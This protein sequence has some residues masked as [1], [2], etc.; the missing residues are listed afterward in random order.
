MVNE[1]SI[2]CYNYMTLAA[3]H[4]LDMPQD[5][6]VHHGVSRIHSKDTFRPEEVKEGDVVFVKT[7]FLY[8]GQFCKDY[9]PKIKHPFI[10]V[11][12]VSSYQVG[13]NGN[14]DY[15]ELLESK[16]VIKWFC[17]NPPIFKSEKVVPIPIGL[18][19]YE[20]PG[21]NQLILKMFNDREFSKDKIEKAYLPYHTIGNN[22]ARAKSIEYLKT[23]D[24]VEVE[25]EKLGF[26]D[27]L[28]K[29]S[30]Y[31][32][33]ICLEGAG[34]DTHRNY[35]SILVGSIP[36]MKDSVIK[37][38]YK[39]N[40]LPSIFIE[41]WE[42]LNFETLLSNTNTCFKKVKTF[43]KIGYHLDI[44]SDAKRAFVKEKAI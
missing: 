33:T 27:Y 25:T 9:F 34:W 31:K 1:E 18:E 7:D 3:D 41:E 22:P 32:Y 43:M 10:L 6:Y 42:N 30:K 17:T 11:S 21:G 39:N 35:E 24:F 23:L 4:C 38:V 29:M 12:G 15:L 36:I 26:L 44:I 5:F 14:S 28:N 40:N 13:S 16:K 8:N 19:E 2:I 20:R 37:E